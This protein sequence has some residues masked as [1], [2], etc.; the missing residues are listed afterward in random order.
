ML[1]TF[2]RIHVCIFYILYAQDF[3]SSIFYCICNGRMQSSPGSFYS[4]LATAGYATCYG[5]LGEAI[6]SPD[7]DRLPLVYRAGY[8]LLHREVAGLSRRLLYLKKV[9]IHDSIIVFYLCN[10][11]CRTQRSKGYL[12]LITCVK[13]FSQDPCVYILH[14]IRTRLP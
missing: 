6:G 1:N 8:D 10:V 14:F 2:P 7:G 12:T 5:L 9:L 13:Y 3:H 11:A 4:R